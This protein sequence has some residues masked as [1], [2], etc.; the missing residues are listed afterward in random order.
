MKS[1]LL[2]VFLVASFLVPALPATAQ[3]PEE[4]PPPRSA[5]KAVL[6]SLLVPGLGHRYAQHG[7]WGGAGTFYVLAEASLWLGVAGSAW[8]Q[9]QVEASYR[10][11]ARA[12]AD[13]QL[14]GKDRR[15]LL[16]LG[17]FRSSDEFLET[18]LRNRAWDQVDY[19]SEPAFQWAWTSEADFL[20]YRRLRDDADAWGRRQTLFLSTLVA[21][22]LVAALTAL[23]A[24]RRA[25]RP[26]PDFSLSFEPP[27][28]DAA[29]PV[30]TLRARF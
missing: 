13:A 19:V 21:N 23:R 8:R 16:N 6:L 15:F 20:R 29:A 22:R 4:V 26:A 27:P 3:T 24:A 28:R 5:G 2:Y 9:D 25:N 17:A 11:L 18:M 10:A 1:R 7:R 12:G 30:V 14:D